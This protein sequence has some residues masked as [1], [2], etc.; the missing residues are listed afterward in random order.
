MKN[1]MNWKIKFAGMLL[2]VGIIGGLFAWG[3]D[4]QKKNPE[5]DVDLVYLISH[6]LSNQGM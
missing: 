5:T 1:V 6:T 3:S 4:V 2:T